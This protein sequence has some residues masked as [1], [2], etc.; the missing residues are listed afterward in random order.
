MAYKSTKLDLSWDGVG[1]YLI[2][3][4]ICLLVVSLV[5]VF[6]LAMFDEPESRTFMAGLVVVIVL[7]FIIGILPTLY[8]KIRKVI[9]TAMYKRRVEAE[10]KYNDV[11]V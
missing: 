1:I 6:L 10:K 2:Q 4:F 5:G 7:S 3:G 9:G 11:G 8:R